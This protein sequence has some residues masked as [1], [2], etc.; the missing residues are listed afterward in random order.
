MEHRLFFRNHTQRER[1]CGLAEAGNKSEIHHSPSTETNAERERRSTRTR[2]DLKIKRE[3]ELAL[4]ADYRYF[5]SIGQGS[6]KK[7]YHAM[8]RLSCIYEDMN[9]IFEW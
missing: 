8:V 7:T 4:V 3:C 9:F 1:Y 6:R 5:E 2:R